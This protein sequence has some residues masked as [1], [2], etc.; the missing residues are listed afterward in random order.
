MGEKGSGGLANRKEKGL[1]KEREEKGGSR[2]EW[3]KWEGV[4]WQRKGCFWED[5]SR[6]GKT[7]E[8]EGLSLCKEGIKNEGMEGKNW[9]S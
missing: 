8:R 6:R 5:G 7:G 9:E 3:D 1:V 2:R 4:R